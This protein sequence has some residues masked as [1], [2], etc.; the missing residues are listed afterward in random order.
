VDVDRQALPHT[1]YRMYDREGRLLYVGMALYVRIRLAAHR[2]NQPW[3]N[4]VS[5]V[6]TER[7]PDRD[8]AADA[9]AAAIRDEAPIF[10]VL[11]KRSR[12]GEGIRSVVVPSDPWYRA[13]VVAHDHG[14]DISAVVTDLLR[15]YA[16][17]AE[18]KAA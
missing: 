17:R 12:R 4:M 6:D 10:N 8:S 7:H 14:E 11:G 18:E 15:E 9:E 16:E 2:N 3:F 13:L 5:K 1:V